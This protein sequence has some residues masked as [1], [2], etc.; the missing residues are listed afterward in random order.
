MHDETELI[1]PDYDRY[2]PK[3]A[4]GDI[5]PCYYQQSLFNWRPT[6][7]F[8]AGIP[9]CQGPAALRRHCFYSPVFY[10]A[11]ANTAKRTS[12]RHHQLPGSYGVPCTGNISARS[13]FCGS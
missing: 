12:S 11:I 13:E 9:R 10:R 3:P 1:I 7:K 5:K 8:A 2:N 4:P 6:D